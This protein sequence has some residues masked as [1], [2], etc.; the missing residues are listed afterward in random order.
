M[1]MYKWE[2]AMQ[3]QGLSIQLTVVMMRIPSE[4]STLEQEGL[5][6]VTLNDKSR[7]GHL[8][9]LGQSLHALDTLAPGWTR[10]F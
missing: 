3:L 6:L 10:H 2:A 8:L 9:C 5:D 4:V 7:G 1:L